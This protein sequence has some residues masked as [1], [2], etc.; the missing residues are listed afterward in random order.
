MKKYVDLT[1]PIVFHW[2]YPIE[3]KDEKSFNKGDAANVKQFNMK[4][5]W[6]THID[7]PL[8]QMANGKNLDDFPIENF[9]GKA[10][11]LD[12][13]YIKENE[14]ITAEML[15]KAIGDD[16]NYKIILIKTSWGKKISWETTDYWDKAPYM[17]EEAA[18]FIRDL[19]PNIVGFDFPQDYDIRKLRF[20]DEHECF[21][22]THE[23]ILKND[24]L[25]IEYL[26]N[27]WEVDKKII[28]IVALPVALKE[29]DGA[30]IRVLAIFE[31]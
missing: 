30:Q 15:K 31:K 5:H 19:K 9:I 6:Y 16:K 18:K 26:T 8:H 27:M 7:A 12:V 13:S 21:L 20:T 22:T 10:V 28:D 25:M 3:I 1:L 24:I 23:Y 29:A 17:T 4:T 2:R 14:G 11:V